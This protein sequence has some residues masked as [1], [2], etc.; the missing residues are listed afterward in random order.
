MPFPACPKCLAPI[1]IR[2]RKFVGREIP[3]PSCAAHI[4]PLVTGHDEWQVILPEE[5][6][7]Q[8]A[9]TSNSAKSNLEKQTTGVHAS[10]GPAIVKPLG[11]N[12]L[13]AGGRQLKAPSPFVMAW[14]GSGVITFCIVMVI[15]QSFS[16]RDHQARELVTQQPNESSQQQPV[17]PIENSDPGQTTGEKELVPQPL[18]ASHEKLAGLGQWL[19]G[20]LASQG[21]FPAATTGKSEN[22]EEAW[23]WLNRYVAQTQPTIVPPPF[24]GSWRGPT[25][26]R[27][28]R[29]RMNSLL[30]NEQEGLI[31]GDG[32]PA[33]QLVGVA[34][35]G[36]D[37]PHLPA[38]SE[39]AGIFA[40]GRTTRQR[41]ILDGLSQTAMVASVKE[42]LASW[43]SGG[44]GG[45]RSLTAAPVIDGPDGFGIVGQSG[46]LLLMADGSVKEL[47]NAAD[48]VIM[49]RMFTMAEGIDLAEAASPDAPLFPARAASR[50][51]M[52]MA[53]PPGGS[54][55][56]A[57]SHSSAPTGI[58][59]E[60]D[61]P[62]AEKPNGKVEKS[63]T[64]EVVA[65]PAAQAP[66]PPA[67]VVQ[68]QDLKINL[69]LSL[70]RFRTDEPVARR[71]LVKS[72]ADLLGAPV[73]TPE[74]P[75]PA[76]LVEILDQKITIDLEKVSIENLLHEI[77]R[78]SQ[79]RWSLQD[80]QLLI[81]LSSEV[82]PGPPPATGGEPREVAVP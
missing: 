46:Q 14:I 43:A 75:L 57:D 3:C 55:S 29:R 4:V 64:G 25:H 59:P 82:V 15:V 19:S 6:A 81:Q 22:P 31:G 8:S 70:Q 80:G 63:S 37:G 76:E 79:A 71:R 50:Q 69:G 12:T 17:Q 77:F 60:K 78:D 27:F 10:T 16:R 53:D 45:I 28:V 5:Y 33:T 62:A 32:Y 35:V 61:D 11:A 36:I 40:Y 23:G 24:E 9:A 39:Y 65:P 48:P 1:R 38:S 18:P 34:G 30:I 2:D 51:T 73:I 67:M 56:V 72:A 66:L 21:A 68:K 58:S 74:G 13:R 42:D 20:E 41:D 54:E 44:K 7:R 26:D 47:T 52:P 49:R